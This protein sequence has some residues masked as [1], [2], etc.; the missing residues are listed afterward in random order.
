M[1]IQAL[2]FPHVIFIIIMKSKFVCILHPL[3]L[4][5]LILLQFINNLSIYSNIYL[6]NQ[7]LIN[8]SF[9]AL[10]YRY[11]YYCKYTLFFQ[12]IRPKASSWIDILYMKISNA[13]MKYKSLFS[14]IYYSLIY[15]YHLYYM[16][17]YVHLIYTEYNPVKYRRNQ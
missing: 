2:Y 15:R 6:H 12:I 17:T 3:L 5:P 14:Y 11:L 1:Y 13:D 4:S 7:V 16:D 10:C 9:Q 8:K